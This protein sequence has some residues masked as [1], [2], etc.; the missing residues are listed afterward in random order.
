M[1]GK[2]SDL[3]EGRLRD[4][5]Y[6]AAHSASVMG[7]PPS[8]MLPLEIWQPIIGFATSLS[9]NYLCNIASPFDIDVPF[10]VD[11]Y[12]WDETYQEE[13]K[14]NTSI[15]LVCKTWR[16]LSLKYLHECFS[17]VISDLL[18]DSMRERSESMLLRDSCPLQ[19][20][21]YLYFDEYCLGSGRDYLSVKPHPSFEWAHALLVSSPDPQPP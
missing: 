6:P 7:S 4:P 20:A 14:A 2:D 16:D 12:Y 21:R 8:Y 10:A 19:F 1:A 5:S 13:K 9:Q 3:D 15:S 18:K 11:E 17:V